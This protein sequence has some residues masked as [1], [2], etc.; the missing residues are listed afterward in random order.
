MS[1]NSNTGTYEIPWVFRRGSL[2]KKLSNTLVT[3]VTDVVGRTR[4]ESN[5]LTNF[6][7]VGKVL[8]LS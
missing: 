3:A 6:G 5:I 1:F 4:T 7:V 2:P 8:R